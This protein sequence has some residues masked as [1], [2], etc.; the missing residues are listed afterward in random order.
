MAQ[1]IFDQTIAAGTTGVIPGDAVCNIE[2]CGSLFGEVHKAIRITLEELAML[3]GLA[4]ADTGVSQDTPSGETSP[5]AYSLLLEN[6]LF[7]R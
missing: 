2:G 3:A 1:T 6:T 7:R 4:T 5:S